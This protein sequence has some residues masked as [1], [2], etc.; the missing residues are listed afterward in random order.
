M[1]VI[2]DGNTRST[3]VGIIPLDAVAPNY[4]DVLQIPILLGR[5]FADGDDATGAPVIIINRAAAVKWPW[6][7]SGPVGGLVQLAGGGIPHTVVGVVGDVMSPGVLGG[8]QPF[9]YLPLFQ[10][11][12]A[13][14]FDQYGLTIHV[15]TRGSR[16]GTALFVR[17]T[18]HLLEPRLSPQEPQPI[19]TVIADALPHE[20][21]LGIVNIISAALGLL[22]SAVGFYAMAAQLAAERQREFGLRIAIGARPLDVGLIVVTWWGTTAGAGLATGLALGSLVVSAINRSQAAALSLDLSVLFAVLITVAGASALAVA[23]PAVIA[24]RNDPAASLRLPSEMR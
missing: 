8:G 12:P 22:V 10:T 14:M 2:T 18:L 15:R 11:V 6:S 23:R 5:S 13:S 16:N 3:R 7:A 4:F 19:A 1:S 9:V 17:D 24:L 20:R 21:A